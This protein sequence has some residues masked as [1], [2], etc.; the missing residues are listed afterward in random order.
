MPDFREY[1]IAVDDYDL[2][3]DPNGGVGNFKVVPK[4]DRMIVLEICNGFHDGVKL[5][6]V[7]R[8]VRV[9]GDITT[10]ELIDGLNEHFK[11][12]YEVHIDDE[13]K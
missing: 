1:R 6:H 12:Y 4:S 8:K 9:E 10:Q 5:N 13:D 7:I 11:L 3:P 2:I